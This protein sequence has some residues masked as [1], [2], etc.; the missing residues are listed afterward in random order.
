MNTFVAVLQLFVAAAFVS[1]P[2]VRH[3][4]GADAM[5]GARAELARQGVRT[6]VL[7]ENG[8]RFDASGH[9]TAAPVTVAAVMVTLAALNLF[10]GPW[11]VPLTRVLMVLVL[12][13]NGVI[14]YSQLTA[15]RS[16]RSAFAR[17]NDPELARVD[18]PALL[19]AAE[20]GFPRW[21]WTLQNVR[22]TVVF[23]A[24]LL[25]LGAPALLG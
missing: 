15:V 2:V 21:T 7:H 1:I 12:L 6:T 8:M 10:D 17:R 20:D 16:V 9:E 25:S 23:G 24:A 18:V 3:R 13:G 4:Y 5:A 19:K 11:A 14:L 22:H